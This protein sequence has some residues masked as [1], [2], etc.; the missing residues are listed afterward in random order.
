MILTAVVLLASLGFVAIKVFGA[1]N[2]RASAP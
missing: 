2:G 1:S